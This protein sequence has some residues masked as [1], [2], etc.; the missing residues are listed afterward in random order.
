MILD[1]S[2]IHEAR[3]LSMTF[4]RPAAIPD[5]Y[6]MLDLPVDYDT[7]LSPRTAPVDSIK[8]DS[9]LFFNATM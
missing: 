5:G 7:I 4:G 1:Q 6:M 2:L 8:H 3:T 9:V